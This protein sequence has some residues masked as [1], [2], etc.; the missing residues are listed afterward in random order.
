M[1]RTA[2]LALRRVSVID[3]HTGGMPTRAVL[4][5]FPKLRGDTVADQRDDLR[6]RF[7]RL[8]RAVVAPPRGNDAVVAALLVPPD[9]A[10]A[11]AGVIF[12]DQSGPIGMCGHGTIGLAHTLR[13]LGRIGEG[14]HLLDTP[15]GQV[16]IECRADGRVAVANVPSR[17]LASG[18]ALQVDGV[19]HVTAD[20]AYGGNTFLLVRR[21]AIDLAQPREALVA[22]TKA[23]LTAAHRAG[24]GEVDHV[25]LHG[26]PTLANASA[27]NFVLCPSGAYDR[28][29]CGTGTS[30]KVACL[31][32]DGELE[33]GE[34]WVQESIT[35]SV[36]T[37]SYQWIDRNRGLIAPLVVGAAELTAECDLLFPPQDVQAQAEDPAAPTAGGL[38]GHDQ[39]PP[40]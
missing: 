9:S 35:G 14:R 8:A 36:F 24:H 2:S 4:D 27:R 3:S 6:R 34:E 17:R 30:A 21:P 23:M 10:T 12:F 22:T 37:V 28:S 39:P 5:G 16:A 7:G 38:S 29:P 32:A 19:G 11:A 18:I 1:K 31:A 20:I 15:A 26:A 25:E 40:P 33:P 13:S